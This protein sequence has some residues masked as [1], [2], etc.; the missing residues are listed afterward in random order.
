MSLDSQTFIF[1]L[2]QFLEF[3]SAIKSASLGA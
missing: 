3:A 2:T 1:D